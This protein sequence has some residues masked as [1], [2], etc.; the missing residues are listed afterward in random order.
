MLKGAWVISPWTSKSKSQ[1]RQ[2]H[3]RQVR[4]PLSA[5]TTTRQTMQA[6]VLGISGLMDRTPA[7]PRRMQVSATSR[8]VHTPTRGTAASTTARPDIHTAGHTVYRWV[9]TPST[10]IMVVPTSYPTHSPLGLKRTIAPIVAHASA[11]SAPLH[12]RTMT[13]IAQC[14]S[15]LARQTTTTRC[16][17]AD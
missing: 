13:S 3:R 5:P 6:V 15:P 4:R 9:L 7:A 10:S 2:G 14:S 17:P 12:L 1:L 11:A 16:V 8:R